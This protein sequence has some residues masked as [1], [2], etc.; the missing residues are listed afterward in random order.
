MKLHIHH[1]TVYRYDAAL[2]HSAQLLRLTPR[3][4]RDQ[5][6][7]DWSLALP[8]PASASDDAYGNRQHLLVLDT[9]GDT[10]RI[11][12]EG[13]VETRS[14][15]SADQPLPAE[16]FLRPTPLTGCDA[17]LTA[18]AEGYRTLVT[19]HGREALL[20]LMADLL[21]RMP[22]LPG[23]TDATTTAAA[24]YALGQGVCQDHAHVFIAAC[25]LL[26]IPARYVSGYL[27][28]EHDGHVASHAWAQAWTGNRWDGFDVSNNCTPDERYVRLA[29]GLDY[30]EAGPVRG[31]RRGGGTESLQSLAKVALM[32]QQ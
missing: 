2:L 25:R 1:E 28:T 16:L 5:Q 10:I 23:Q 15:V 14:N 8:A 17:A 20:D 32:D 9:P 21:D 31:V 30:L 24:A 29:L 26:G 19:H 4:D 12:A 22:Y 6:V 3:A 13:T 27:Y 11:V 18:F 7:I